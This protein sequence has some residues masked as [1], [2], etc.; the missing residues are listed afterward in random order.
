M[1]QR[2]LVGMGSNIEPEHHLKA[3]AS[4]IRAGFSGARFSAVYASPAVGMDEAADFLTACCSLQS[5]MAPEALA[6]WLKHL[7]DEHGRD[8]SH[9]SWKP[10][11]LDLDIL[12]AGEQVLDDEL[13]R[14]AHAYVPASELADLPQ[15]AL[16]TD[17]LL[18]TALAL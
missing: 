5:D 9:G 15:V 6:A 18:A 8:R 11:T 10:R 14:Y 2:Y 13:F 4:A 7:E 12:M 1:K 17:C 16:D 3:A